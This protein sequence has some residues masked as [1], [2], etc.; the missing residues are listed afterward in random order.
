MD[1]DQEKKLKDH[2]ATAPEGIQ[3]LYQS[4]QELRAIM[5]QETIHGKATADKGKP[6]EA[7]L[8]QEI[9]AEMEAEVN[10]NLQAKFDEGVK[11]GAFAMKKEIDDASGWAG[12]EAQHA[13]DLIGDVLLRWREA[14]RPI[15]T[16]AAG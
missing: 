4:H 1:Q 14:G 13:R 10:Q 11:A 9:R 3:L 8:R 2:M 16:I 7:Q 5:E 6:E 15:V 12:M